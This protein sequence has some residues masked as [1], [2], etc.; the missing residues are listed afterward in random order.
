MLTTPTQMQY[1]RQIA[2]DLTDLGI[3]I[4]GHQFVKAQGKSLKSTPKP[5][6]C[7]LTSIADL[8]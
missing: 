8:V 7:L 3:S 6:E 2:S 4:Q 1:L 5:K